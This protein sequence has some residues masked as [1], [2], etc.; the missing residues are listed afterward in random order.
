MEKNIYFRSIGFLLLLATIVIVRMFSGAKYEDGQVNAKRL[1]QDF[2][3][4]AWA[5]DF[6]PPARS[7]KC[8][9]YLKVIA[10]GVS[11][12]IVTLEAI[13]PISGST[14]Q[15]LVSVQGRDAVIR[16][17]EISG[18]GRLPFDSSSEI[19]HPY[20]LG[21]FGVRGGSNEFILLEEKEGHALIVYFK[22]D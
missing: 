5:V 18:R 8:N 13:S 19:I 12:D 10:D 22:F 3:I 6:T 17:D 2:G 7:K 11:T 1:R 16:F 20:H 21:G 14:N 4:L 15:I 9:V